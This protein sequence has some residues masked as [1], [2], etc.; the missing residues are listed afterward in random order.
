MSEVNYVLDRL[1]PEANKN[2]WGAIS[3]KKNTPEHK[4]YRSDAINDTAR[5]I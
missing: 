2:D 1:Y 5:A 3:K 4:Y